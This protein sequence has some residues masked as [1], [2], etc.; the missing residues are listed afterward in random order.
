MIYTE[1]KEI[2]WWGWVAQGGPDARGHA[3]S[4]PLRALLF[5]LWFGAHL[6]AT[7]FPIEASV[8]TVP[9]AVTGFVQKADKYSI[10]GCTSAGLKGLSL[11]ISFTWKTDLPTAHSLWAASQQ[12]LWAY[13]S[14]KAHF[15][16]PLGRAWAHR[17]QHAPGGRL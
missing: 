9:S 15:N 17:A 1:F 4:K 12:C 3:T 5:W 6:W 8:L 14:D 13:L 10:W 2:L 11:F 16:G 7:G